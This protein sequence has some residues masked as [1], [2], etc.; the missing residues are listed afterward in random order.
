MRNQDVTIQ[1]RNSY[2]A[3]IQPN[4]KAITRANRARQG[5]DATMQ[6]AKDSCDWDFSM[7]DQTLPYVKCKQH[8]ENI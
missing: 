3:I 5:P 7:L 2:E 6:I 1:A 4:V 8:A